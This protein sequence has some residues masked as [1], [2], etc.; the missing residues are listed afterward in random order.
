MGVGRNMA[1]RKDMFFRQNGFARTLHL[2][3]GDDDLL[4]NHSANK[5]NTKVE[6]SKESV[7]WSESKKRYID[8][9]YQK[10]RHLSVST[11]YTTA[12]R[13]RLSVEPAF[14]ALFYLGLIA[15]SVTLNVVAVAIAALLFVIRYTVQLVVINR[16]AKHFGVRRHYLSILIF[17]IYLPV[18]NLYIITFGRMGSQSKRIPWK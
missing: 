11:Y 17:D 16:S 1:Y 15:S 5:F 10:E 6:V 18:L 3:S 8:W 2:R 14:R 12:S 9:Y 4:V 13:F 7:T